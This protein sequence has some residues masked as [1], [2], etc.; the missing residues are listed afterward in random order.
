MGS[1]L[2]GSVAVVTQPTQQ[3]IEQPRRLA[4]SRQP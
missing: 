2:I 1:W 3:H 4:T